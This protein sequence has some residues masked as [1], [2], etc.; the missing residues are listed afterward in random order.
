MVPCYLYFELVAAIILEH[1]SSGSLIRDTFDNPFEYPALIPYQVSLMRHNEGSAREYIC[2]GVIFTENIIITAA[3]CFNTSSTTT[4]YYVIVGSVFKNGTDGSILKISE[5]VTHPDFNKRGVNEND[6]ALVKL[7]DKLKF[8]KS[9]KPVKLAEERPKVGQKCWVS[10]WGLFQEEIDSP[11]LLKVTVVTVFENKICEDL[12]TRFRF[13]ADCMIC[14]GTDKE[15]SCEGDSGGPLICRRKLAG[16]LT[17][18]LFCKYSLYPGIYTDV[19]KLSS[20][21]YRNVSYANCFGKY[22]ISLSVFLYFFVYYF[23]ITL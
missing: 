2:S 16:I 4:G 8:D 20:W 5:L 9:I 6:I 15:I 10:G 12:M 3:H 14:A 17:N 21:I 13:I 1:E 23:K 18:A 7:E 19:L 11:D 22:Y